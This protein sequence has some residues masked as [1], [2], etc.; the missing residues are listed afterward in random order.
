MHLLE[1]NNVCI[2]SFS[3]IY[4]CLVLILFI[5]PLIQKIQN[6]YSD[7]GLLCIVYL[8]RIRRC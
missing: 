4:V 2:I 8:D 5:L 3:V 7:L 6:H 1:L